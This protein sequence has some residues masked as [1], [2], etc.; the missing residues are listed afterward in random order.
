MIYVIAIIF[1]V[2][3]LKGSTELFGGPR[4][5]TFMIYMSDVALGGHTVFPQ[6]GVTVKPE[7]GAAL[8]WFNHDAV[9]DNDSR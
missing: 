3:N 7:A 2:G 8:Y 6:A 9:D 5:V 1:F 4:I